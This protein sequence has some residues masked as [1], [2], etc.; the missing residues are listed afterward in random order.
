MNKLRHT[1]EVSTLCQRKSEGHVRLIGNGNHAVCVTTITLKMSKTLC[2]VKTHQSIRE[3]ASET[4]IHRMTVHRIIH[5]DLQLM[6][7]KRRRA[8]TALRHSA[9]AVTS[10][11]CC[12]GR[13]RT[14]RWSVGWFAAECHWFGCQPVETATESVHTCTGTTFWALVMSLSNRYLDWNNLV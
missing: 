3:I 11:S 12:S 14:P 5:R 4:G 13:H 2:S 6:C 7:I 1:M 10:S 8:H 9:P